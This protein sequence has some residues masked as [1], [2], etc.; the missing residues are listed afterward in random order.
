MVITASLV[1]E[2]RQKTGVGLMECKRVL[3]ET[4]GDLEKAITKLREKGLAKAAKKSDRSTNEGKIF[5]KLNNKTNQAVIL[6]LNCE[7]DF[8]A[9]NEKFSN[10]GDILCSNILE[11]KI[12]DLESLQQ[13]NI[14]NVPFKDFLS[15]YVLTLGENLTVK[16]FEYLEKASYYSTYIHMNGKIGT[17]VSF[18]SDI[19][20]EISK[21]IAMHVAAANPTYLKPENVK[22]DEIENEKSIIKNQALKEG[23]PEQ[24]VDKIVNGRLSKFYKEICLIEQPF[25]KDDKQSIKQIL[26]KGCQISHFSRFSLS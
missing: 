9:S 23:K 21:S 17:I 8:V 1:S 14:N 16:R 15:N 12:K 26:P 5:S 13:S 20:Q 11:N 19:D 10:C 25:I 24:I 22:A 2:L 3:V 6:E 4:N 7:T 18:N